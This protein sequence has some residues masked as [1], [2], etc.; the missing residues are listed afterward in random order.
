MRKKVNLILTAVLLVTFI[1]SS[2]NGSSSKKNDPN[3]LYV[4]NYFGA[5]GDGWLKE[6]AK[7]WEALHDNEYKIEIINEKD[8]YSSSTLA[9]TMPTNRED[10]YLLTGLTYETFIDKGYLHDITDIVT[11]ELSEYGETRT[12]EEK[13]FPQVRD[14]YNQ[15]DK[16]YALPFHMAFT[17][18]VYD[19]D[20]FDEYNFYFNYSGAG[21]ITQASQKKSVGP[22]GVE[23]TDDDGLPATLSQFK[24]LLAEMRKKGVKPFTWTGQ[25]PHYRKRWLASAW[26][27]YEGAYGYN[28]NNNFS[29]AYN[30]GDGSVTINNS[31]AYLLQKQPGKLY[32][33]E[34]AASIMD[35]PDYYSSFGFT[36]SQSHLSAQDEF[37]MSRQRNQP[38]GMII[39]NTWWESEATGTF[40]DMSV[41]YGDKWSKA[42]RRF[43]MLP[44]PKPDDGSGAEE[45]TL[46]C[47][48][49][50]SV[51]CIYSGSPKTALAED[52]VRYLHSDEI[53][54]L[55]HRYTGVARAFDYDLTASD[56]AQMTEYT[57]I[58]YN[59]TNNLNLPIVFYN[60]FESELR[61]NNYSYFLEWS[62]NTTVNSVP[63]D[64]PFIA[65]RNMASMTPQ[66]YFDGLSAPYS[67]WGNRFL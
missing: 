26:V 40:N 9:T 65:F 23:G 63:Y 17:T 13:I 10:M 52:F 36:T 29:G 45:M 32:A 24:Q 56:L 14:Y 64:D 1:L 15:E 22:D 8:L 18:I 11:T 48:G 66:K 41:K 34:L 46:M 43:G 67:D 44:I 16:Y 31:N 33:L 50:D 58:M 7:G 35:D 19:I 42:N 12:I 51:V 20:L 60:M 3:T 57:K 47:T 30:F 38:I 59:Y 6:A 37:L 62:W 39:E 4:G 55:F 21:F 54:R 2:C 49:G 61:R 28:L 25:Y 53:L 27:D 5:L